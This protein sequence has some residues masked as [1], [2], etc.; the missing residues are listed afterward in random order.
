MA[1]GALPPLTVRNV[2]DPPA[3][4]ADGDQGTAHARIVDRPG[5][6]GQSPAGTERRLSRGR[7][8][9]ARLG[10]GR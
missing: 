2:S 8:P 6:P 5:C 4:A 7:A 10:S 3:V 9:G 1:G